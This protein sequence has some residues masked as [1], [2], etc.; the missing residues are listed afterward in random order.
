MS[1]CLRCTNEYSKRFMQSIGM[2]RWLMNWRCCFRW[3][4]FFTYFWLVGNSSETEAFRCCP[5]HYKIIMANSNEQIKMSQG[6]IIETHKTTTLISNGIWTVWWVGRQA[7][8]RQYKYL[9]NLSLA[10]LRLNLYV[11]VL[12]FTGETVA[13]SIDL[14]KMNCK[15]CNFFGA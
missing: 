14:N 5:Q 3:F 8:Q 2:C 7:N 12:L 13:L 10:V 4:F 6:H 15:S 9:W 11:L 1:P